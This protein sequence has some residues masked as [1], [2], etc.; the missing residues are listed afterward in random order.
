MIG[1]G[2]TSPQK[3]IAQIENIRDCPAHSNG[4]PLLRTGNRDMPDGR[5][6]E[7]KQSRLVAG[8]IVE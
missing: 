1:R 7:N 6:L 5:R 2:M 4:M 8:G 3:L